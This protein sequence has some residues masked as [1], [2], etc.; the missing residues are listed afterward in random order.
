M[1][2]SCKQNTGV[3]ILFQQTAVHE[4]SQAAK[5]RVSL[6]RQKHSK[7]QQAKQEQ[8]SHEICLANNVPNLAFNIPGP[9]TITSITLMRRYICTIAPDDRVFFLMKH[10]NTRGSWIEDIILFDS[11][12]VCSLN[13]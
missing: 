4:S 13:V 5:A 3:L 8:S 7:L 11:E 1:K 9:A 10:K 12:A 2:G 6:E